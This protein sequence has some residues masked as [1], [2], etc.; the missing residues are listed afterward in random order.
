MTGLT[1]CERKGPLFEQNRRSDV[2]MN[3]VANVD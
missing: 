1:R 3:V 2:H